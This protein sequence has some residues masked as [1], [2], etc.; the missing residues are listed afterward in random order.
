MCTSSGLGV[1]SFNSRAK[2]AFCFPREPFFTVGVLFLDFG[3]IREH[4]INIAVTLEGGGANTTDQQQVV[5]L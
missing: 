3:G 2:I 1:H 5:K 4:N